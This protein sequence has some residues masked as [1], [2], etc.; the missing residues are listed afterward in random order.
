MKLISGSLCVKTHPAH[1]QNK[2]PDVFVFT[3]S[4]LQWQPG[5][6]PRL[7]PQWNST[8]WKSP[9]MFQ[10]IECCCIVSALNLVKSIVSEVFNSCVLI[11]ISSDTVLYLINGILN[12]LTIFCGSKKDILMVLFHL[13]IV[14]CNGD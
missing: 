11:Q 6:V 14:F 7:Y 4:R 2:R 13:S 9:Y 3:L 1:A 10:I 5:W 12:N 8:G